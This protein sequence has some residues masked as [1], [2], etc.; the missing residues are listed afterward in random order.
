MRGLAFF[1]VLLPVKIVKMKK[2]RESSFLR[3]QSTN[4][5]SFDDHSEYQNTP[6]GEER[7]PPCLKNV[8]PTTSLPSQNWLYG[9]D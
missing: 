5:Q 2:R 3:R 4:E 8:A 6:S 7:A 9:S 1:Y